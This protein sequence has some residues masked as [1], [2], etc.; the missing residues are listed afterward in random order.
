MN[1]VTIL[2][3]TL[4]YL[5][6]CVIKFVWRLSCKVR[7]KVIQTGEEASE[8]VRRELL[9]ELSPSSYLTLPY[10]ATFN[11]QRCCPL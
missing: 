10:L 4:P 5:W 1:S 9:Q 2:K 3:G 7:R 11:T 6:Q 8:E